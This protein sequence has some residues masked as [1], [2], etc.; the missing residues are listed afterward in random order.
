MS[1]V[2]IGGAGGRRNVRL[3]RMHYAAVNSSVFRCA[4]N[5]VMVV[6]PLS[7]GLKVGPCRRR[8]IE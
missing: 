5:V 7:L 6:E 3:S 1:R 2:R 8:V 4:L